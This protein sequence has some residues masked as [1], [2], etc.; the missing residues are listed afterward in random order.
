MRGAVTFFSAGVALAAVV[1][2]VLREGR[3]VVDEVFIGVPVQQLPYPDGE[4][5]HD[6]VPTRGK[7]R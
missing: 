7:G 5:R 1:D 4:G 3:G 6:A 2:E